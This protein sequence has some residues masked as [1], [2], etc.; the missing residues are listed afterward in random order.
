MSVPNQPTKALGT[1]AD[2]GFKFRQNKKP[3]VVD[4]KAFATD[5]GIA[6]DAPTD[7]EYK[8]L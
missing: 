1:M 4:G 6:V 8:A 2:V 3:A 7:A 5:Y